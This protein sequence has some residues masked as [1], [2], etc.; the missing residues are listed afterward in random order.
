MPGLDEEPC[1]TGFAGEW[2][3]WLLD[4]FESVV[5]VAPLNKLPERSPVD[6]GTQEERFGRY[7]VHRHGVLAACLDESGAR[8]LSGGQVVTERY[9][10]KSKADEAM[11]NQCAICRQYVYMSAIMCP[12][13]PDKTAC[14]RHWRE[15]CG[16]AADR[17][18]LAL[19]YSLAELDALVERVRRV[20]LLSEN[21]AATRAACVSVLSTLAVEGSSEQLSAPGN[22]ALYSSDAAAWQEDATTW[23]GWVD[24]LLAPDAKPLT[25]R[26]LF[27][28]LASGRRFI[29]GPAE[30]DDARR[31]FALLVAIL[32]LNQLL[33]IVAGLPL[34]GLSAPQ[35]LPS[36]PWSDASLSDLLATRQVP[37]ELVEGITLASLAAREALREKNVEWDN[38]P[39]GSSSLAAVLLTACAGFNFTFHAE[40]LRRLSP[41]VP[42][43][44]AIA[45]SAA[46]SLF[47]VDGMPRSP[48]KTEK[49]VLEATSPQ[50]DGSAVVGVPGSALASPVMS[51]TLPRVSK[52]EAF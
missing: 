11:R 32:R 26:G 48:T 10:K 23:V 8:V 9:R 12:C 49:R 51:P 14:L 38:A 21:V 16:C 34:S 40:A 25:E 6:A 33:C 42:P 31:A 36:T 13:S 18:V 39:V 15:L 43:A 29:S 46:P 5:Q 22:E 28:L 27:A 2:A 30:M 17:R 41:S 24:K 50:R 44:I 4:S 7:L 1:L 20:A 3:P 35:R 45:P 19:R 47:A 37:L 52:A